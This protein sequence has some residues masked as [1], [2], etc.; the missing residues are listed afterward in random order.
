[1][2]ACLAYFFFRKR[3]LFLK[4]TA[5]RGLQVSGLLRGSLAK[6]R[7]RVVEVVLAVSRSV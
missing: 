3:G 7:C 1:M 4:E 2:F 5:G 6:W